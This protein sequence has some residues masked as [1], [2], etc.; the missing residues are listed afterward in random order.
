VAAKDGAA[1]LFACM[2]VCSSYLL[3]PPLIVPA[4]LCGVCAVEEGQ[5]LEG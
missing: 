1:A 4:T 3:H 5:W 2:W